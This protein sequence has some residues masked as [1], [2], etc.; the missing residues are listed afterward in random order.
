MNTLTD[1]STIEFDKLRFAYFE[2]GK[3]VLP[4]LS[5]AFSS[6]KVTVLTGPS[7]CG[8][9]TALYL[10][11]GLYPHHAGNLRG[12]CVTIDGQAMADL[13][14]SARCGIVGMMFQ[15][16]D[17][18]F[19][20]DTVRNELIFCLENIC[21]DPASIAER[22]HAAL[23]FCEI[24]HLENRQLITLSG[25]EKQRV[26]LACQIALHPRWV[27][28][29]EPFAN[30]DSRSA[31][32]ILQKLRALHD[33]EG[34][35]ILAVDHRL[36]AWLPIADEIRVMKDGL[37]TGEVL[38]PDALDSKHL[39][40]LGIIVPGGSYRKPS[41]QDTPADKSGPSGSK[42]GIE[43]QKEPI[44]SL[45][46]VSVSHQKRPSESDLLIR[47]LNADLLPGRIYALTGE[48][49][50]GKST[51]F[52]ALFGLYP[53]SG[54][55]LLSGLDLRKT[56]K[57]QPGAIGFVTQSP[58][59]QFVG[60]TVRQEIT[61]ALRHLPEKEQE[62]K[63]EQ[64]LRGIKLWKYRD[65]SPYMLSQ[66]QQRRLGV[67]ALMAYPCRVLIC[68]E[69][70]Y[71]QDRNNTIAIMDSLSAQARDHGVTLLFST[72]DPQL[73]ADY[74]DCVFKLENGELTIV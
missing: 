1:K 5:A 66:G 51:L 27:L 45:R 54:Q 31:D 11:A 46:D 20:M 28:L 7:G 52:G 53:Y 2:D 39:E 16:P 74:A 65:I 50:C 21:A 73:A 26:M 22:V 14:A 4:G 58:Q 9:S 23:D 64:I 13:N 24:S 8:K 25:G 32:I 63:T 6:D 62:A 41:E 33:E 42:S 67:A 29:D 35:G 47:R 49:G 61:S 70:T 48:S 18:Q 19:C 40:E 36:D 43:S 34:I 37:L 69:P 57:K 10:A 3:D 12:G 44:L 60:G 71:A 15:N 59:D 30:V 72:H 68:D 17:L 55:I 56:R 38:H